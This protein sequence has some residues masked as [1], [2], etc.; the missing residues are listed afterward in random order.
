MTESPTVT[1]FAVSVLSSRTLWVAVGT[2][3]VGILA[4]PDVVAIIPLRY[5]PMVTAL[6]GAVNFALRLATVRP[7]AF[8]APGATQAVSVAKVGPPSPPLVTD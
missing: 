1:Y 8:I 6:I 5:L 2:V 3:L 4:L 7:V